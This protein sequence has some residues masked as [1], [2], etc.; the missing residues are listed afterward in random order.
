MQTVCRVKH[1]EFLKAVDELSSEKRNW[2]E[3][4]ILNP[5]GCHVLALPEAE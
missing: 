5:E 3:G 1:A 4:H 2:F